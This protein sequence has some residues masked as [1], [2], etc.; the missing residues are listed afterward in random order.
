MQLLN[1]IHH[2]TFITA[3]MNRLICFYERI[4]GARVTVDLEEE[5]LRHAFIEW[6]RTLS[7]T[8]FRSLELNLLATSP[9]SSAVGSTTLR[10]M[11]QARKHSGKYGGV[12]LPRA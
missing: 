4:F 1:D 12:S 9:C 6:V 2:L 8:H 5:G 11:P 7:C 3:D 10:S